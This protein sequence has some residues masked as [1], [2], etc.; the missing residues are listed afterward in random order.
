MSFSVINGDNLE[1]RTLPRE[2]TVYTVELQTIKI[3][4]IVTNDQNWKIFSNFQVYESSYSIKKI[5]NPH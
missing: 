1:N 3:A 4:L 2:A 5:Q